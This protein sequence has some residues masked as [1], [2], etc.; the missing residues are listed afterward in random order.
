MSGYFAREPMVTHH[1]TYWGQAQLQPMANQP[2]GRGCLEM[3]RRGDAGSTPA[4]RRSRQLIL[5]SEPRKQVQDSYPLFLMIL[6]PGCSG[7]SG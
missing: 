1:R 5:S 3:I 4:E 7:N 6:G 2:H